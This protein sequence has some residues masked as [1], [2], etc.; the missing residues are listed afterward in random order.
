MKAIFDRHCCQWEPNIDYNL[1]FLRSIERHSNDKL[2][3]RGYV[4]IFEVYE[5]LG[6][7]LDFKKLENVKNPS[8][9]WWSYRN[10]NKIDFGIMPIEN[11]DI[12]C[13]NFNINID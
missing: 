13:L 10:N 2:K 3:L 9:L 8:D 6:L 11:T 5:S 1:M 4:T 12:V 7:K